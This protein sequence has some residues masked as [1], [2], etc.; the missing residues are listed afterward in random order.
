[1]PTAC[2]MHYGFADSTGGK[3]GS[4]V[5]ITQVDAVTYFNFFLM[6]C[7]CSIIS[8]PILSRIAAS[9]SIS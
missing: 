3:E 2:K 5:L 7:D 4:V 1:M 9:C 6:S 8:R